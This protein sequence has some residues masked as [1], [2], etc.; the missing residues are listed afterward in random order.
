MT[1]EQRLEQN[2]NLRV[3]AYFYRMFGNGFR[4]K[5]SPEVTSSDFLKRSKARLL[6]MASSRSTTS[7]ELLSPYAKKM[8][9]TA[10]ASPETKNS[11]PHKP[12]RLRMRKRMPLEEYDRNSQDSGYDENHSQNVVFRFA[13]PFGVAPRRSSDSRSPCTSPL[14]MSPQRKKA[15]R[16]SLFHSLSSGYESFDDGFNELT[17]V[18]SLDGEL[19]P[20]PQ[21]LASLICGSFVQ[22]KSTSMEMCVVAT[23]PPE[24][25]AVAAPRSR[26]RLGFR[27][28][29]PLE[30]AAPKNGCADYSS[31]PNSAPRARSCLFRS[32]NATCST[33]KLA[34]ADEN[35]ARSFKRP[36]PP[37]QQSPILVKRSRNSC[38]SPPVLPGSP[39]FP[40]RSCKRFRE[41]LSFSAL[42][43]SP[44]LVSPEQVR[45]PRYEPESHAQVKA[46]IHRSTTD[47]DLTGDFSKT[48]ILPLAVGEHED[49]KSI[50][51]ETLVK[52]IN[53]DYDKLVKDFK[54]VDCRYPYEFEAGHVPGAINLYSRDMIEQFLLDPLTHV[55][56][57]ESESEKRSVI[58]FHCEF[59]WERGP[60]LSR[61]LRN[62]DRQ[63]NKEHYPALHYPEIYLLHGG[64]QKFYEEQPQ[65]CTPRG[66]KPMK[67]P[68][69]ESDL[70]LFRSKSKTWQGEKINRANVVTARANLKRLGF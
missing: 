67:D 56:S 36:E 37:T 25:A 38:D 59:S 13:E 33:A 42:G 24:A 32:P 31:P 7:P 46:A 9:D 52:L 2:S 55:P 66:Y 15:T 11:T 61:F 35:S 53:G 19:G 20:R 62:I 5:G 28:Q 40:E 30:E 50:S 12:G 41:S 23:T 3:N 48:C 44:M 14:G 58:I 8:Y 64:Y 60:N 47:E 22:E 45:C 16:S 17:D 10:M 51:S 4:I 21:N 26:P 54:I 63:R 69:H 57:I 43:S 1:S 65:H 39:N 29:L 49:L 18:D 70:K 6:G 27:S 34:F 68:A